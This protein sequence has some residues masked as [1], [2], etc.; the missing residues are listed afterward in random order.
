LRLAW[1]PPWHLTASILISIAALVLVHLS[2][3]TVKDFSVPLG[4]ILVILIPGYLLVLAIF[5][6]VSDLTG[7][8]RALLSLGFDAILTVLVCMVLMLTP[9]GLQPASLATI[10]SL[11][12]LFLCAVAHA[13]WSALPRRR[14]FVILSNSGFRTS[15]VFARTTRSKGKR[16]AFHIAV[17]LVAIFAIAAFAYTINMYQGTHEDAGFTD[18]DYSAPSQEDHLWTNLSENKTMQSTSSEKNSS[19]TNGQI[20]KVS[21][22]STSKGSSQINYQPSGGV[23]VSASTGRSS[24]SSSKTTQDSKTIQENNAVQRSSQEEEAQEQSLTLPSDEVTNSP[25]Q[26]MKDNQTENQT[27]NQTENQTDN[28][29]DNQTEN[30]TIKDSNASNTPLSFTTRDL[31]NQTASSAANI[32]DSVQEEIGNQSQNL[33]PDLTDFYPDVYSPQIEGTTVNWA[34]NASDPDQDQIQYRFLLNGIEM[35][36]WSTANSWIWNT[37]SA[38]PGDYEIRVLVRDGK[39]APEDSFD[40]S[41]NANFTLLAQNQP[42]ALLNLI[43]DKASPQDQGVTVFWKAE[44]LDPDKD[45]VQYKFLLN[46]LE[47]RKWSKSNIWSW[48]TADLPAGD[49]EI[50]VLVRDGKHAPED[51]FD[52]SMNASFTLVVPN[53]KPVVLEFKPDAPSPQE[54]A[55]SIAWTAGAADAEGDQIQ[56]RFLLNGIEMTDWSTANSWIWNTS[57]AAPGDYKIS[58]LVRDG[59]HAPEGS[60]DDSM[61]ASF[62]LVA[63]N[64]PPALLR[65]TSDKPSPQVRGTTVIWKADASDPDGD[66]VLYRFLVNNKARSLW[67]QSDTWSWSTANMPDGNYHVSV[68]VRDGR[69][70]EE[71]SFDGSMDQ[72]FTLISEIDQQIDQIMKNKT[73]YIHS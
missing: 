34:A 29:T 26:K 4:L 61:D 51:S 31:A 44:S 63:S 73:G 19:V 15:K 42:P 56:Y 45:K 8:R 66:T 20:G 12:S 17:L 47:V 32:T 70:A 39:H 64:R 30:Q 1:P 40:D 2:P 28:Q 58:V 72:S 27:D 10:L 33:P 43:P 25:T 41:M 23:S 16:S 48:A 7:K 53:Q 60:F 3:D 69:H 37:S 59:K 13:R 6:S 54:P 24:R 49:Y 35:T 71:E 18:Y 36:D 14:R 50:R 46:G 55:M 57:S 5:P 65:L 21:V 68:Q 67:S 38:A 9:R 22:L 52:D 11:L 62:T